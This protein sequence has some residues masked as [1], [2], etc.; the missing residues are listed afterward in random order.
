MGLSVVSADELTRPVG[1]DGKLSMLDK[2]LLKMAS[3]RLSPAEMAERMNGII[4][5]AAAAQRVREI[6]SAWDY[7]SIVEQK[8]LILMDLIELKDILMDRVRQEGGMVEGKNGELVYSFGDPRWASAVTKVLSEMGKLITQEQAN[9]DAERQGVRRAHAMVMVRAIEQ[10]FDRF[11]RDLR[12]EF[13]SVPEARMRGVLEE[14]IPIAV[15][16][17]DSSITEDDRISDSEGGF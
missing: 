3:L 8:A 6:L 13:P 2:R 16:A 10:T 4:T 12:A 17:I 1:A 14:A 9:V 15:A 11:A 7:L 5:P